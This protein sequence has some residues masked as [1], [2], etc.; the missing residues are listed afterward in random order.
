MKRRWTQLKLRTAIKRHD[1]ALA[2]VLGRCDGAIVFGQTY[3][4]GGH[5]KRAHERCVR[6][7]QSAERHDALSNMSSAL[8]AGLFGLRVDRTKGAVN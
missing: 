1:C 8:A 3:R 5:G 2:P 7:A 4:D 6:L